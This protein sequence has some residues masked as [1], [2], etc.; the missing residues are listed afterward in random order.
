[1]PNVFGDPE[2]VSL[3]VLIDE[4]G[5]NRFLVPYFQRDF[6]WAADDVQELMRSLFNEYYVGSL[7]CWSVPDSD[8]RRTMECESLWGFGSEPSDEDGNSDPLVVLD[9]QQRLTAMHYVFFGSDKLLR[10]TRTSRAQGVRFRFFVDIAR[11][12]EEQDR[13]VGRAAAFVY[14][15]ETDGDREMDAARRRRDDL[16]DE[17][18]GHQFPLRLLGS[19]AEQQWLVP[20]IRSLRGK[21]EDG[22][23]EVA[24]RRS[25][26][27]QY[28]ADHE[29]EVG[30]LAKNGSPAQLTNYPSLKS[31]KERQQALKDAKEDLEAAQKS[32][33]KAEKVLR[34]LK[35][36]RRQLVNSQRQTSKSATRSD[37]STLKAQYRHQIS[38]AG[39]TV[40]D[41]KADVKTAEDAVK[42][43]TGGGEAAPANSS[44]WSGASQRLREL[45]GQYYAED[46]R[47]QAALHSLEEAKRNLANAEKFLVLVGNLRQGYN[48]PMFTIPARTDET[49][50]GDIFSQ[51]NR[52][53][54]QLDTFGLFNASLSLQEI[55]VGKEVQA[56]EERLRPQGLWQRNSRDTLLRMMVIRAK[57]G[58]SY[59]LSE[60]RYME[61]LPGA[62]RVEPGS[63]SPLIPDKAEFRKHWDAVKQAYEVGMTALRDKTHFGTRTPS[64]PRAF[65]PFEGMLPVYCSL[66]AEAHGSPSREHLV[67]Q[68]YWA[69]VL[70]GRYVSSASAGDVGPDDYLQVCA[71]LEQEEGTSVP[72]ALQSFCHSFRRGFLLGSERQGPTPFG[73]I[74]KGITSLFLAMEPRSL[75]EGDFPSPDRVVNVPIVPDDWHKRNSTAG[76]KDSAFGQV[77]VTEDVQNLMEMRLPCDYLPEI[78]EGL[79]DD[80]VAQILESHCISDET[81]A[82]L[83]KD[84]LTA[85]D[86]HMFLELREAEFLRQL[87]V[88]VFDG[89]DLSLG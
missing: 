18:H 20:Y 7:M 32:L 60:K 22:E 23:R 17:T 73:N 87:S 31:L 36:D 79:S 1:M 78:F 68:W 12:Y 58:S 61:L 63:E 15:E 80:V 70:M 89:L 75:R 72:E 34:Q 66:W 16:Y 48:I 81:L 24:E 9:G 77:L 47:Y 49:A 27:D 56:L 53:G 3:G 28:E 38:D 41:R 54:V 6:V 88:R 10:S 39:Q 42:L 35:A 21:V 71:W 76:V 44:A 30:R 13:V 19:R 55:P 25:R 37:N 84:Q 40:E 67:A 82:L 5:E 2:T 64:S 33:G 8:I 85:D 29:A 46:E 43:L 52:R 65:V 57:P 86:F 4:I 62:R 74:T 83:M 14:R 11:F 69:S 45:E 59:D 26:R 50:V 51:I